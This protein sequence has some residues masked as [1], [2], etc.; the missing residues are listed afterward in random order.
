MSR[1][2]SETARTKMLAAASELILAGGVHCFTIDE[3]A[4]RSGVAKSTIYRHFPN[5][6]E[7]I[8]AALDGAMAVPPTPDTGSLREDLLEFLASVLPIFRD[9]TLRAVSFEIYAAAMLDPEL[10]KIHRSMMRRRGAPTKAIFDRGQA[11]GEISP[12]LDYNTAFEIIEGPLIVRCLTRPET[13][14]DIELEPLVDQMLVT[15]EG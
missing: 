3:V 9:S 13:L 6:N 8:I 12:D 1:P 10:H 7:L 15:L 4:R 2:L 11:R 14:D 5:R